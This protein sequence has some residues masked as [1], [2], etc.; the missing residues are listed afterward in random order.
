MRTATSKEF[1][2]KIGRNLRY[3][4][5][6]ASVEG[7]TFAFESK[8]SAELIQV[9]G[10]WASDAYKLYLQ[11]SLSEKVT[12]AKAMAKFIPNCSNEEEGVD[13]VRFCL[14]IFG[15][16]KRHA[17]KLYIE[18]STAAYE[19]FRTKLK[20]QLVTASFTN[21]YHTTQHQNNEERGLQVEDIYKIYKKKA[22]GTYGKQSECTLNSYRTNNSILVNGSDISIFTEQILNPIQEF[23]QQTQ[24]ALDELSQSMAETQ[25]LTITSDCKD[26]RE[27]LE[28]VNKEERST[29]R[30]QEIDINHKQQDDKQQTKYSYKCPICNEESGNNT[31]ACDECNE[32]FH[33]A[34]LK[35]TEMEVRKIDPSIP[36]ICE[37]WNNETLFRETITNP[38]IDID[39]QS[40]S[41][42]PLST[43]EKVQQHPLGIEEKK[44]SNELCQKTTSI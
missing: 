22:D 10:D 27:E 34:C 15:W 32:W 33:Y 4:Q 43:Y 39:Q 38:K 7:A 41:N 13:P 19:V 12:V 16:D 11:F 37:L 31:I 2:S 42:Q 9:H 5:H 3:F 23:I 14:E 35:L 20:A 36:Y 24:P 1:I 44:E 17:G 30:T 18:L 40:V 25:K 29:T 28:D 26:Q 6:T 21:T 8:V